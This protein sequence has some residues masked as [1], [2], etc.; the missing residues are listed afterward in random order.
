MGTGWRDLGY[1]FRFRPTI[2]PIQIG[3]TNLTFFHGVRSRYC[4]GYLSPHSVQRKRHSRI[5]EQARSCLKRSSLHF[6]P[7]FK[8]KTAPGTLSLQ[9]QSHSETVSACETRLHCHSFQPL[10]FKSQYMIPQSNAWNTAL[11]SSDILRTFTLPS[12]TNII[13]P[14]PA[15]DLAHYIL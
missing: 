6:D 8:T 1:L 13:I 11:S 9:C 10:N 15:I 7:V 12:H 2:L 4:H 14:S 3:R 5:S